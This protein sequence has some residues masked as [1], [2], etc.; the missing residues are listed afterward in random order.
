MFIRSRREMRGLWEAQLE[1]GCHMFFCKARIRVHSTGTVYLC[2]RLKYESIELL[3]TVSM[4][5]ETY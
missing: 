1:K 3:T 5:L 2:Y 4:I